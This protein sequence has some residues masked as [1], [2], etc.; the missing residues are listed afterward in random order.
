M[1]FKGGEEES[2]SFLIVAGE[3]RLNRPQLVVRSTNKLLLLMESE[4]KYSSA[5]F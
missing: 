4:K 3:L 5:G 1:P 2:V